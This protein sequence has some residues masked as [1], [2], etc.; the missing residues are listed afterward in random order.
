MCVLCGNG[1]GCVAA[2]RMLKK[3]RTAE[4]NVGCAVVYTSDDGCGRPPQAAIVSR[5]TTTDARLKPRATRDARLEPR[6]T[7]TLNLFRAD[8]AE[9]SDDGPHFRLGH[10][11]LVAL[12]VKFRA[13][14]VTDD[15]EDF[16]V[17]R[18]AVP[19]RVGKIGGMRVF[20]RH[21]SV[22]LGVRAVAEP[23]VL[24]ERRLASGNR[25]GVR[26]NG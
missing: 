2:G 6:E 23:A 16:A 21:R 3:S 18:A 9:E 26:G 14:T 11:A 22:A 13:C 1:I 7:N 4:P 8:A 5:H 24:R 15:R 10:L 19:L 25:F 12:H 17:G 20:R